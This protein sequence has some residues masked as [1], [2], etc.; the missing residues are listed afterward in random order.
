M[1]RTT[2]QLLSLSTITGAVFIPL[3]YFPLQ[4]LCAGFLCACLCAS[5]SLW[6][7]WSSRSARP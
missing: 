7:K 1:F 6:L 2:L 3:L 4:L 5:V